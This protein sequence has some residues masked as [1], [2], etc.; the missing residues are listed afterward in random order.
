MLAPYFAL[1]ASFEARER[2][3][4]RKGELFDI[5]QLASYNIIEKVS[6]RRGAAMMVIKDTING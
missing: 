5:L 3:G 4:L 2:V 1:S 6:R